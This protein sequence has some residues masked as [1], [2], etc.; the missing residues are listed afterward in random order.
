MGWAFKCHCRHELFSLE[1]NREIRGK[2]EEKSHAHVAQTS[3]ALCNNRYKEIV[4]HEVDEHTLGGLSC[5]D[6]SVTDLTNFLPLASDCVC[7]CVRSCVFS[8]RFSCSRWDFR[9]PHLHFHE[10]SSAHIPPTP[11]VYFLCPVVGVYLLCCV[12]AAEAVGDFRWGHLE[13]P[14]HVSARPEGGSVAFHLLHVCPCRVSIRSLF[15][16]QLNI[17]SV[18]NPMK[19]WIRVGLLSELLPRVCTPLPSITVTFCYTQFP[20]ALFGFSDDLHF[21]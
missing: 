5:L 13:Q 19:S 18:D 6:W 12:E 17:V 16:P 10:C 7:V 20:A 2:R 1:A 21:F 15:T 3:G 8:H 9:C 4:A 11:A 14:T